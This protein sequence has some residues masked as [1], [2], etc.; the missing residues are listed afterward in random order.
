[1]LE[2]GFTT[3]RDM[4]NAG[5]YADAAL[6]RAIE[7]GIVTGPTFFVSG[8]IIAPFGG[9]FYVN[10]EH[11]DIGKQDYHYADNRDE[12]RK[13]IR[14]NIH[15]GADWIKIVVDDYPYSYSVDDLRFIVS[16]AGRAGLKVAAHC[17]TEEGARGAVEAG[18]ASIEHGFEMSDDTLERAKVGGIWLVAT[19]FTQEIMDLYQFFAMP[20]SAIVDRLK[21]AHR[22]GLPLVYGSDIISTI[23]GHTRGSASLSLLDS[24]VEAS[25]PAK[26]ILQALTTNGVRLLGI[27]DQR[28]AIRKGLAADIIATPE[29]PLDNIMTLKKVQFVMKDG[30]IIRG[31]AR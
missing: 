24:W 31:L 2:A 5:E 14:Q 28:G 30:V 12:I 22:I 17:V 13:A 25:V 10:S 19:D 16:E 29:N 23:P 11:P 18:I 15:Y 8:K 21:R 20:R 9:Q 3:V 1:M 27:E 4:G 6:Q 26:A 7:A